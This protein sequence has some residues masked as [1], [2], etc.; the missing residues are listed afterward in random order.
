[1]GLKGII[2]SNWFT[3]I[4]LLSWII[5]AVSI[6]VLLKNME[7]IVHGQLYNYNLEFSSDWADPYRFYTWLIYISLGLPIALSSIAL[8]SSFLEVKKV[9]EK[10]IV[11][12]RV[13]PSQVNVKMEP[14]SA[15]KVASGKVENGNGRG[16]CCPQC[17]KIFGR[18]LVM[19]DFRSGKNRMVSVCP[20]CNHILGYTTEEKNTHEKIYVVRTDQKKVH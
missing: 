16:I 4:V 7:V 6:F 15:V 1:M 19:L 18:S 12:Q 9:P 13:K 10:T 14:Q 11:P 3:R 2:H 8:A 20:Y 17:K 5:C